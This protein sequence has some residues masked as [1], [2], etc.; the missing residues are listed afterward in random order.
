MGIAG[1]GV[2]GYAFYA[3]LTRNVVKDRGWK[4][5]FVKFD[6]PPS[7]EPLED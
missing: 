6:T 4:V 7:T 3:L 2:V 1:L 5:T